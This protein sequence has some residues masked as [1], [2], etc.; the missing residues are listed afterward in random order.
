[1]GLYPIKPALY[2]CCFHLVFVYLPIKQL[3]NYPDAAMIKHF[4]ILFCI[5]VSIASCK[6]VSVPADSESSSII[7]FGGGL[8]LEVKDM[9]ATADGGFIFSGN[10]V[11]GPS[12]GD[13]AF[14]LKTDANGKQ[15]WVRRFGGIKN[16]GFLK[17]RQT[18]D[19]G[20]I[21]VG[22][23]CSYGNGPKDGDYY[24]DGWMLKTDLNGNMQ[25]QKIYGDIYFDSLSDI[26]EM[27]DHGFVSVGGFT[28]MNPYY[29]SYERQFYMMRTDQAGNIKWENAYM[30]TIYRSS[31]Q[32][33]DISP[34][35]DIIASGLAV[36]SNLEIDQGTYFPCIIRANAT[37]GLQKG[38]NLIYNGFG[39]CGLTR[40]TSVADGYVLAAD[41]IADSTYTP[42][43][44]KNDF[45]LNFKWQ[46]QYSPG[47]VIANLSKSMNGGFNL[48][49][50]FGGIASK[51][52][53]LDVD[54]GGNLF[55]TIEF[56]SSDLNKDKFNPSQPSTINIL[57]TGNGYAVGAALSSSSVNS[58]KIFALFFSDQNGKITDHGK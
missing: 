4:I 14:L 17:A 23:T 16:N 2:I 13:L 43:L 31:G 15:Q 42:T 54:A 9:E 55:S 37:T 10:S 35:G 57:P 52:A 3:E 1:M 53:L 44:I 8:S 12:T 50:T 11:T 6:K 22:Y 39:N 29:V 51:C 36:K 26:K 27:P 47:F 5:S 46:K 41:N 40:I 45:L 33:V 30:N 32:S 24:P 58:S 18:S 25:W 56:G 20:Y 49:G 21:A 19:G 38:T 34:N 7:I 48:S 28:V